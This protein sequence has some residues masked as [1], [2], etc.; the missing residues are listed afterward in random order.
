M[1][2][3][4]S[5]VSSLSCL[6][7]KVRLE[8]QRGITQDIVAQSRMGAQP[9]LSRAYASTSSDKLQPPAGLGTAASSLDGLGVGRRAVGSGH[10]LSAVSR[11]FPSTSVTLAELLLAAVKRAGAGQPRV[12]FQPLTG[13]PAVGRQ[14]VEGLAEAL[15][16]SGLDAAYR[17]TL[18]RSMQRALAPPTTPGAAGGG[19]PAPQAA[20]REELAKHPERYAELVGAADGTL[21]AR[22]QAA[23]E[24]HQ[25]ARAAV[26]ASTAHAPAAPPPAQTAAVD[27]LDALLDEAMDELLD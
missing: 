24:R 9:A 23:F 5:W 13:A 15:A 10:H 7:A 20:W 25:S 17:V 21:S 11:S 16:S 18:A 12:P 3:A 14:E 1:S 19:A 6:P 2:E 22:V 4:T 8:V 26:A 27:D